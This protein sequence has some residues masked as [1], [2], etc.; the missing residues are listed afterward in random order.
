M[1]MLALK[2]VIE[3]CQQRE[4]EGDCP[5]VEALDVETLENA[6]IELA[7]RPTPTETLMNLAGALRVV[8]PDVI[9]RIV[10]AH[11]EYNAKLAAR[12][13]AFNDLL[14]ALGKPS[15]TPNV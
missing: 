10:A 13:E 1:H 8:A 3:T 15:D 6:I 4:R 14:A 5:T 11:A 7:K 9:P 12:D 2:A